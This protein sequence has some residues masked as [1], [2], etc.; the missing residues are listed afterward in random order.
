MTFEAAKNGLEIGGVRV[1]DGAPIALIAG[2]CVVESQ[3]FMLAHAERLKAIAAEAGVGLVFKSSF[4]KAN[5]TRGESPR[6]PGIEGGL[7]I[8]AAVK[9]KLGLPILTDVHLPDQCAIAAEVADVLQIPAFLCRQT[10]LLAAAGETGRVV[11]IKKGQFLAAEDMAYAAEKAVGARGI[12]VTERG[13]SFG[14][15]DLVVD[16][17]NFPVLRRLAP[18]VFD[19]TH[20]VQ[21]PGA[22]GG[23]TGGDRREVPLLVRAAVAVGVDAVF[24]EVHPDPD[25]APSDGPN[26]LDYEG[27]IRVLRE[28]RALESALALSHSDD[29]GK[30]ES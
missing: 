7:D 30:R 16:F 19:G 5:R 21:R 4:D 6:G 2:P 18:L 11:N 8:L 12:L 13:T 14:Y 15:R 25:H 9:A 29:T 27:L 28:M 1:G 24:L 23:T 26:S 10:D 20:S 17:R 22:R 3:S